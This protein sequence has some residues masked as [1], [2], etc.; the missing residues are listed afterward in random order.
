M[1]RQSIFFFNRTMK[2]KNSLENSS[3]SKWQYTAILIDIHKWHVQCKWCDIVFGF[4]QFVQKT[5]NLNSFLVD[6]L[7]PF[8]FL[9]YLQISWF[10]N[11]SFDWVVSNGSVEWAWKRHQSFFVIRIN[12][13]IHN[14]HLQI[15]WMCRK[16]FFYATLLAKFHFDEK[17]WFATMHFKL[18]LQLVK[19][20]I[21]L[22]FLCR[23]L[24]F[25]PKLLISNH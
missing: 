11:V 1:R 22:T 19:K 4:W 23:K 17:S 2:S 21:K 8:V 6:Q 20:H 18:K 9:Y 10:T 12:L 15:T 16:K 5:H 13:K 7:A 3:N 25:S 14:S 24:N